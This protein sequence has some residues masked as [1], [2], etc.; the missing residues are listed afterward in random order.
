MIKFRC[1]RDFY[2]KDVHYRK[3]M[4]EICWVMNWVDIYNRKLPAH[5]ET[6]TDNNGVIYGVLI[7]RNPATGERI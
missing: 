2:I 5:V 4:E 6:Q 7:L 3:K 1:V